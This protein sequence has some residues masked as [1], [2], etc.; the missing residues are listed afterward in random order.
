MCNSVNAARNDHCGQF[1]CQGKDTFSRKASQGRL[2]VPLTSNTFIPPLSSFHFQSPHHERWH[3]L[4]FGVWHESFDVSHENQNH[5]RLTANAAK[6]SHKKML[7]SFERVCLYRGGDAGLEL[8]PT[9]K[10]ESLQRDVENS[11]ELSVA[12]AL[13][14]ERI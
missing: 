12:L 3:S 8:D 10:G 9:R 6:P 1:N 5:W 4:T 7:D 11:N 2:T 14:K 13:R